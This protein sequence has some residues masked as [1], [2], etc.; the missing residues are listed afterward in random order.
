[1]PHPSEMT[2]AELRCLRIFRLGLSTTELGIVL[3][4]DARDDAPPDPEREPALARS[5]RKREPLSERT[6]RRWE[7]EVGKLSAPNAEALA[8]L[9]AYTD[10]AVAALVDAHI[11]GRP[12]LTYRDDDD[13]RSAEPGVWPSLPASWH[14]AVADQAAR[15]IPGARIDY[16]LGGD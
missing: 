10:R 5:T 15:Q 11:P 3:G 12:I 13:L 1:M 4:L 9:I 2:P 7:R 6:V 8:R 16:H 14:E